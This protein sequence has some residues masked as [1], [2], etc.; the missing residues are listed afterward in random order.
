MEEREQENEDKTEEA[1]EERRRQFREQGNI[2]S[3]REL[4]AALALSAFVLLV[5]FSGSSILKSLTLM[6]HR[7]FSL[8]SPA[9]LNEMSLVSSIQF[10]LDPMVPWLATGGLLLLLVPVLIGLVVTRFHWSWNKLQLDFSK[11]NPVNGLG[12]MFGFGALAEA[13]KSVLKMIVIASVLY[14]LVKQDVMDSPIQIWHEVPSFSK[15]WGAAAQHLLTVV[16]IASFIYGVSDYTF[17]LYRM[18]R[19]MMMSKREVKEEIKGQEGDP[20]VKSARRRMARDL[21]L[22]RNLNQVQN[23]T[24]IVTNPEHFAVALRYVK[25]M[26]APLVVAKGQDFLALKIREIAKKHDIVIVENKPL[27]RTLYKTVKIGQ[28]V[29]SSLYASVIEV[30]KFIYRTRGRSYFDRFGVQPFSQPVAPTPQPA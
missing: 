14:F 11:L 2:A 18:E 23:A 21:V 8:L 29:P 15:N 13:V 12:R 1:S 28:E 9:K 16:A 4:L 6:F 24:F 26:S 7:T 3:P 10:I 17:N 19:Q 27:A 5:S 22:R 25:G 20:H 30:M